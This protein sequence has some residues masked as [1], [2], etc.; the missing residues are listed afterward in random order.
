MSQLEINKCRDMVE[1]LDQKILDALENAFKLQ[2][3]RDWWAKRLKDLEGESVAKQAVHTGSQDGTAGNGAL[4][5]V[6]LS[7]H[8]IFW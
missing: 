1:L 7:H 2:D 8:E 6:G 3:N 5:D 4:G